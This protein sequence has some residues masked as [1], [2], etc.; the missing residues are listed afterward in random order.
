MG[1]E[2]SVI[3]TDQRLCTSVHICRYMFVHSCTCIFY[4]GLDELNNDGSVTLIS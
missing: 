2:S 3:H 4:G 1:V